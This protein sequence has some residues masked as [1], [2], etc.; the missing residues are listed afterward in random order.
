MRSA[1]RFAK[2]HPFLFAILATVVWILVMGVAAAIAAWALHTPMA[3]PLPQSLGM[4]AATAC[5]LGVMGRWG[6]L[7][8]AGIPRLGTWRLWL[9]TVGLAVYVVIAYQMAFFRGIALDISSLWASGGAQSILMRQAVVGVAEETLFRGFQL[10]VLVRAW[11]DS[12]RGLLAAVAVPALIFGL[13]HAP[14]V[15]AG[16]PMDDTLMTMLNCT[17]SGLWWGALVLMG[18]SIWP[19]VLLHAVSNASFQIT[20]L[21]LCG[22]NATVTEFVAAT[23]A[24]LPLVI[25]GL[26]LVLRKVPGFDPDPRSRAGRKSIG[27]C[28][29]ERRDA[30]DALAVRYSLAE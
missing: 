7:R 21:G 19:A 4:L 6:W 15:L 29:E 25:G 18:G 30:S 1:Q 24:E 12:R 11:G 27:F 16:N 20:A 23:A 26:W 2:E 14:Q 28:M 9:V 22:Y 17:V 8:A 13:T 5:L 10:F 3:D